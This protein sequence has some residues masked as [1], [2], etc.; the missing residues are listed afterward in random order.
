MN[1]LPKT[2]VS[3]Q[4]KQMKETILIAGGTGLVG[5]RLLEMID[6]TKYTVNILSRKKK[7]DT[8]NVNYFIWDINKMEIEK[9]AVQAD[10]IINFTGA[11]IAD[12]RWTNA[13]KKLLISSRVE[14]AR[15]IK[16]GLE[17]SGHRPKA[18]ISASAIGYYGDRGSEK[19]TEASPVGEGFL[20]VCCERWEDSAQE[21]NKLVDR[22]VINRIGIVLS[23]KGGALPKILMTKAMGVYSYF[24][25]GSQYYS[26]IHIDDLCRI[27]LRNITEDSMSGIYNTVAPK[28]LTNKEFT[29]EIKD[30]LGG[31]AALPAPK[32]GLRLLL[33]EMAD[34]VLNSNRGYPERLEE[35][36]I[37]YDYS[38]LGLAV[39]DLLERKI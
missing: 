25:S 24:G 22:L 15:L 17:Q 23:T 4:S 3:Y 37:Y 7:A 14:S 12:A 2:M 20:A 31:V 5:S 27:F 10:Y 13:R 30:A 11:G 19:L 28:P 16:K 36:K 6:Y 32:F 8:E 21:L 29:I 39:K 9:G 34:V 1:T 26:W 35:N 33:G 38:D 18:Y